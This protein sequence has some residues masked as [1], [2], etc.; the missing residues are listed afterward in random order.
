MTEVQ[1][2]EKDVPLIVSRASRHRVLMLIQHSLKSRYPCF[3]TLGRGERNRSRDLAS[4]PY[5]PAILTFITSIVMSGWSHEED[6]RL[7]AAVCVIEQKSSWD[8]IEAEG[9]LPAGRSR[10]ACS[11]H[12]RALKKSLTVAVHG[13]GTASSCQNTPKKL[14]PRK[15]STTKD[16]AVQ[17]EFVDNDVR[18]VKRERIKSETDME[19]FFASLNGH[20]SRPSSPASPRGAKRKHTHDQ[21]AHAR[22]RVNT[23]RLI[24][25]SE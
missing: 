16:M 3:P 19:S 23:N 14:T 12:F 15:K 21:P 13:A 2:T 1:V 18:P 17:D 24:D 11:K 8:T 4:R 6:L 10:E 5:F 9:R 7:L 20:S 22:K 25:V